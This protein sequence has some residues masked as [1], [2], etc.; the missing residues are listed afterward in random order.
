MCVQFEICFSEKFHSDHQTPHPVYFYGLL[1]LLNHQ[2]SQN[3]TKPN[4]SM[5][6]GLYAIS[7]N[8]KKNIMT[9]L[10]CTINFQDI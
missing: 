8:Y 6:I 7:L 4:I 10:C 3:K 9:L 2:P 5:N 1:F